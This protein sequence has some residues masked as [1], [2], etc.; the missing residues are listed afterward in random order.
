[1]SFGMFVSAVAVPAVPASQWSPKV[2][3]LPVSVNLATGEPENG[4]L[5]VQEG[6]SLKRVRFGAPKNVKSSAKILEFVQDE[7]DGGMT[8]HVQFRADADLRAAIRLENRGDTQRLVEVHFALHAPGTGQTWWD[9]REAMAPGTDEMQYER[10]YL[11]L[12][13]SAVFNDGKGVA[14]GLDPNHL[15]S[16]FAASAQAVTDGMQV[17]IRV[18]VVLDPKQSVTVPVFAFG[19]VPRYGHLDAVQR[20]YA[21]FPERFRMVPGVRSNLLTQAGGYLLSGKASRKLQFEEGRRFGM[22]WEWAYCPAQR[23]GDWYSGER[24]WDEKLGYAGDTDSH[25]NVVPGTLEEFRAAMRERFHGGWPATALAYFMFPGAAEESYIHAFPDG[26]LT[27][28]EGKISDPV[29]NWIKAPFTTRMAYPWGNS[30]GDEVKKAIVEVARDFQPSA[31]A[32]DE[33]N[34][35]D[36]QYGKGIEGDSGRAWDET[37]VF[38]SLQVAMARLTEFVHEQK[39]RGHTLASVQNKPWTY[40]S[41]TRADVAMHEWN[42]YELEDCLAWLRLLMGHKPISLWATFNP[43]TV[44]DWEN[45]SPEEIQ[46]GLRGIVAFLRLASLRDGTLPMKLQLDGL[47][48]LIQ[49]MPVLGELNRGGWQPV[50]AMRDAGAFWLSRYG[51]GVRSFLVLGNPQNTDQTANPIVDF[52]YLGSGVFLFGGQRGEKIVTT[53]KGGVSRIDAGTVPSRDFVVAR[54]LVQIETVP[55]CDFAGSAETTADPLVDGRV[56]AQWKIQAPGNVPAGLTIRLPDGAVAQTLRIGGGER[57]FQTRDGL[58]FYR[59]EIPAEGNLELS[60]IPRIPVR[61]DFESVAGF[62]FAR[63]GFPAATIVIPE[64]A[65]EMDRNNAQRIATYFDWY[66]RRQELPSGACLDLGVRANGVDL[67]IVSGKLES[68]AVP[69]VELRKAEAPGISVTADGKRLLVEG[70]TPEEREMAVLR[71]VALLDKRYPFVGVL[72]N[73]PIFEKAG[74]AGKSLP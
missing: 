73:K 17:G 39:V 12:P 71:L 4:I 63:E 58:V 27:D 65:G 7:E 51:E 10:N 59:G 47:T 45:L 13:L 38:C 36:R 24:F 3:G 28:H 52:E 5:S 16:M 6:A 68:D 46:S 69:V 50:P 57:P 1:M 33:A 11:R 21:M 23:P 35:I 61:S 42:A 14:V 19:F 9:G 40:C 48:D 41:A 20:L 29:K 44:L 22:G 72:P 18:R 31:I 30:Y 37:G 62:P 74:L 26:L 53:R 34:R 64:N 55:A 67:P 56:A 25:A 43:E 15:A 49:V 32:F 8:R 70:R 2:P 60:F 66:A 54:A